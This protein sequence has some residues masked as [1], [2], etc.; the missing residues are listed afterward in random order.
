[1]TFDQA[2]EMFF[3]QTAM[4]Q[5]LGHD[6]LIYNR[7]YKKV[8]YPTI[9]DA[10]RAH[11]EQSLAFYQKKEQE[12][13]ALEARGI[14]AFKNMN[15]AIRGRLNPTEDGVANPLERPLK[16]MGE[17][18][19]M[20]VLER[21]LSPQQSA[22]SSSAASSNAPTV[23]PK[24]MYWPPYDF[25]AKDGEK[26]IE[27]I[28]RSNTAKIAVFTPEEWKKLFEQWDLY[29]DVKTVKDTATG[30]YDARQTARNL[31]GLG[32]TAIVKNIDGV[33][34]LFLNNYDK[35][36]Q[37]ILHGGIFR[38]DNAQVVKMGLGALDSVKGM[39]RYVKVNALADFLV[40][41]GINGLKYLLTD[42]YSLKLLGVDSAKSLVHIAIVSGITLGIA[43]LLTAPLT[44]VAGASLYLA[45]GFGVF[46]VDKITDFEKKLVEEVIN[47]FDE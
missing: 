45:V 27:V 8:T 46:V 7:V 38:A 47:E 30:L 33:E 9:Q 3:D 1:M 17:I 36:E 16:P 31:G 15:D 4:Q 40:G 42:D 21:L 26:Q 5:H 2:V 37:T 19:S 12:Q 32:V 22:P 34:Y 25:T 11:T 39:T 6:P 28:Y 41:S 43:S 10:Q 18:S 35:F 29:G 24:N 20:D 14:K 44:F 23:D 13:L